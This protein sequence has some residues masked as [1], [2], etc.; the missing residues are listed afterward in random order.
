[1]SG[2]VVW[3]ASRIGTRRLKANSVTAGKIKKS[4]VT[5]TKIRDKAVTT[6]KLKDGAVT[7]A[8]IAA[9]TNVVASA[10]GGPVAANQ[11]DS[12][13]VPLT[14]TATFTPQADVVDLLSVEAKGNNLGRTGTEPCAPKV[15]PFVNGSEW[16]AAE[17]FLTVRAG[18]PTADEP[19]GL[20]PVSGETGPIGLTSP[21]TA[22]TV[23]AKVF[24]DVDCTASSTVSVAIAVTQA[25]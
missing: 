16:E 14:G 13:A 12:I 15:V 1:L 23:S 3:A 11:L 17:G 5:S 21:G 6:G 22:Q 4:A 8:K 19:S 20:R 25:K 18:D 10:S 7:L 2:G 9:G 24:G